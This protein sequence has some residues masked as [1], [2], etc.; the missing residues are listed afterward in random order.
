MG[1]NYEEID[2]EWLRG[3]TLT[4]PRGVIVD[5]FDR[6]E[7]VVGAEWLQNARTGGRWGLGPTF[8]VVS[9]GV[10]LSAIEDIADNN[11]LIDA[12]RSGERYAD[13]ELTAL[14]LLRQ[15]RK[16][17][18]ELYP[19]VEVG[20]RVKVP[21][22]KI[23]STEGVWVYVEV[24]KADMSDNQRK[25]QAILDRITAPVRRITKSFALQIDL[26][27]EPTSGELDD[28]DGRIFEL[29]QL[30]GEH[31]GGVPGLAHMTVGASAPG[32]ALAGSGSED[33]DSTIRL[34]MVAFVGGV[35]EPTRHIVANIAVV[36]ERAA[37][38]LRHEAEQLP[39]NAPGLVMIDASGPISL[40]QWEIDIGRR[41]QPN[42]HTRVAAVVLFRAAGGISGGRGGL[43]LSGR[44]VLNTHARIALPPSVASEL[45]KTLEEGH[46][47]RIVSD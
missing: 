29:C 28:L 6:A 14:Y 17:E 2:R 5:A 35:G 13:A 43:G 27:R 10:K 26:R 46:N 7:R 3:G 1:W 11:A 37:R 8:H 47:P 23:R 38:F 41:L 33:G 42:I 15:K 40:S 20:A 21:D 30:D 32:V 25:A 34:A 45:T 22:F 4:F 18:T 24:T 12:L 39:T 16:L 9:M 31:E 19:K 44:L 36:D